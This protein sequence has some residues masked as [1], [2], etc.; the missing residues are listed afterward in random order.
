MFSKKLI[1]PV[2]VSPIN[3]VGQP[4]L[5][6][7][8]FKLLKDAGVEYFALFGGAVRDANYAAYYDKAVKI[9]DY[10]VRVWLPEDVFEAAQTG[11]L[12]RLAKIANT[13]IREVP[14]AGTGRIRYCLTFQQAEIDISIRPIASSSPKYK[15]L[16]AAVAIDRA[17]DCDIG[18]SAV[19]IDS[20]GQAWA[21]AEYLDDLQNKTLTV[22]PSDNKKRIE[23]Y[24]QRMQA[25]FP[26]HRVVI[27]ENDESSIQS[28][29]KL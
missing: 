22:Y 5:L 8:L 26:D 20:T 14:S 16:P 29:I 3:L 6:H 4:P 15:P 11:F 2:I 27:L 7:D 18:L 19:A 12:S 13:D 28:L 21:R 23:E 17:R 24:T 9:N 10:D 1:V 25:K